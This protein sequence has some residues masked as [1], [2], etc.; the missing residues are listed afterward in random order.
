MS[1]ILLLLS[2]CHSESVNPEKESGASIVFKLHFNPDMPGCGNCHN[3]REESN[4][5]LATIANEKWEDHHFDIEGEL[6]TIQDCL[7]CHSVHRG[8]ERGSI[9]QTSLR[10]I[11]HKNHGGESQF[12]GNCFTCHYIVGDSSPDLY[13]YSD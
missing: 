5:L 1:T 8:S 3:S 4:Q 9:A 6:L 2:S 10:T 7:L 13:N 12:Q 11:V